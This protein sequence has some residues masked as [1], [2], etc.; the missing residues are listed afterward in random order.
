MT[1]HYIYTL[2]L[3]FL[4]IFQFS[5]SV[6]DIWI[7]LV[8]ILK[9]VNDSILLMVFYTNCI[10][11]REVGHVW[12]SSTLVLGPCPWTHSRCFCFAGFYTPTATAWRAFPRLVKSAAFWPCLVYGIRWQH[13][14]TWVDSIAKATSFFSFRSYRTDLYGCKLSL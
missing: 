11:T 12:L 4:L 9:D 7:M 3:W 14:L 8:Y 5:T 1:F 13:C 6:W 10:P 2:F